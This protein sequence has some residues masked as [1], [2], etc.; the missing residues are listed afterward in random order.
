MIVGMTDGVFDLLHVGHVRY[1]QNCRY[2]CGLLVVAV[3][4]DVFARTRGKDRPIIGQ[5]DRLEL[6]KALEIVDVAFLCDGSIR[7]INESMPDVYFKNEGC[8][9][10]PGLDIKI[11]VQRIPRW[12]G[13]S[14]TGIIEKIRRGK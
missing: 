14:T 13:C 10:D 2:H 11:R 1:L 4:D 8:N 12:T 3:A 5:E 6:V 7:V 9:V